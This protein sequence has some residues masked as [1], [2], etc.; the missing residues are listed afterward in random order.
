MLRLDANLRIVEVD[1][2]IKIGR[3]HHLHSTKVGVT[4]F[5]STQ[6]MNVNSVSSRFIPL[7]IA[8][9]NPFLINEFICVGGRLNCS[10]QCESVKHPVILPGTHSTR[11]P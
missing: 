6:K 9:L 2:H 10:S 4:D 7:T 11:A 1:R 3:K 8:E 5:G